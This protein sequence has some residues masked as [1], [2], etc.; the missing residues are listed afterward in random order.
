MF[1]Q[2]KLLK[3]HKTLNACF[4]FIY[5][6]QSEIY[7]NYKHKTHH[8]EKVDLAL[9]CNRWDGTIGLPGGKMEEDEDFILGLKR[10]LKE[11]INY[12]PESEIVPICSFHSYF[13]GV[14]MYGIETTDMKKVI[15]NACKAEH[16]LTEI[17]GSFALQF[18]NHGKNRF[19]DFMNKS[20]CQSKLTDQIQ[21][22][23]DTLGLK[24]L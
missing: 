6:K 2:S 14:H 11:E 1:T 4:G 22:A 24:V 10:E 5:Q 7:K 18:C 12:E 16:F 3:K 17:T 9:M 13:I 20:N 15:Q 21:I 8:P 19:D 23:I